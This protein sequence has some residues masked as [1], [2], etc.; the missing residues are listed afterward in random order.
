[1]LLSVLTNSM[2]SMF[3]EEDEDDDKTFFQ[4]LSQGLASTMSS[5]ILG[6]SFGN[7]TKSAINYGV[8]EINEEYL[9]EMRNGD[10]DPYKDA[11]SFTVFPRG[12]NTGSTRLDDILV[13]AG[14]S[15]SPALKTGQLII[16]NIFQEPK[17]E[18]D[19]IK[20]SEEE[21]G[22]RIP[23]EVL[24][25]AGLVPLYKDVRKIVMS[26]MYKDLKVAEKNA[27]DKKKAEEEMLHGYKNKT[28]MKR[29]DPELYE[30]T[31]GKDSPDYDSN[32]ALK[33]I[34][35]E[36]EDL[37]RKM[38]D[39]FYDYVPKKKGEKDKKSEFGSKKFGSKKFG[40]K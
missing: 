15:Y 36:K 9:T 25:N 30:K 4:K 40:E 8:E 14:G 17:K 39:E 31:F 6:R 10:Y 32:E 20:R 24:G 35:K 11:I 5:L 22:I 28:E 3:G 34:R 12:E 23:L 16:K 21:Q 37:E 1:M 7:F 33:K 27:A 19:A 18:A 29:Y 13:R 38:K 2:L 26:E